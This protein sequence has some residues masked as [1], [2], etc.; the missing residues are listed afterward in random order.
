MQ[1]FCYTELMHKLYSALSFLGFL[2]VIILPF[3]TY[4][5]SDPQHYD[6]FILAMCLALFPL[7][8]FFL[9]R[10]AASL[11]PSTDNTIFKFFASLGWIVIM[12]VVALISFTQINSCLEG[13]CGGGIGD[14]EFLVMIMLAISAILFL[15]ALING[16]IVVF[17]KNK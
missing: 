6:H 10:K 7:A 12:L 14:I 3:L 8:L 11:P 17:K 13:R 2:F 16:A 15:L 4:G 1:S 5:V 9:H